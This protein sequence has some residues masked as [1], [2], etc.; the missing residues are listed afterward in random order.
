[1]LRGATSGVIPTAT[2]WSVA[3]IEAGIGTFLLLANEGQQ[4]GADNEG[5]ADQHPAVDMVA[6]DQV[7]EEDGP[8]HLA[9]LRRADHGGG[10]ITGGIHDQHVADGSKR[11]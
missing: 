4:S 6:E 10:R 9:I 1:M 2:F 11:P 3:A 8:E 7:T 5:D